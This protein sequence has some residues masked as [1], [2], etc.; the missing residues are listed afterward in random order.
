MYGPRAQER[1]KY[2]QHIT[3]AQGPEKPRENSRIISPHP[4]ISPGRASFFRVLN[5]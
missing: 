2:E 5:P 4:V 1:S 3:R